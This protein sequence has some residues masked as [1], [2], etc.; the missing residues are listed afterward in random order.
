MNSS[1]TKRRYLLGPCALNFDSSKTG[2]W[3]IVRPKVDVEKC[4]L[5]GICEKH[6][7]PNII[8]VV[9]KNQP[10]AGIYFDFDYCKGCGI[11]A[12][13]CPKDAVNMVPEKGAHS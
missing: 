5:C 7:P 8:E 4:I 3:R 2:A 10:N 1:T 9:K 13:V 6:C 12:D 11:C